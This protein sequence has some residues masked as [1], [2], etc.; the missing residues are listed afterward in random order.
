MAKSNMPTPYPVGPPGAGNPATLPMS[1]QLFNAPTFNMQPQAGK[2]PMNG[3]PQVGEVTWLR[4]ISQ[5]LGELVRLSGGKG[6]PPGQKHVPPPESAF[7]RLGKFWGNVTNATGGFRQI[8]QGLARGRAAEAAFGVARAGQAI[9][10]LSGMFGGSAGA[11]IG[12]AAV[13]VGAAVAVAAF[14]AEMKRAADEM[15]QFNLSLGK[16][17]ASMGLVAAQREIQEIMRERARGDALANSAGLLVRGEQ[18]Y[19]DAVLPWEVAW[20]DLKNN[21]LA[22]FYTTLAEIA[23]GI[24]DILKLLNIEIKSQKDFQKSAA[25]TDVINGIADKADLRQREAKARAA[26]IPDIIFKHEFGNPK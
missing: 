11:A 25:W 16:V 8:G 19:K 14:V 10:S 23:E 7:A 20:E 15:I 13:P 24:N 3:P 12:A 5:Q 6:G 22:G 2:M 26:G 9:E 21:F 1:H 18:R 4:I 17:S